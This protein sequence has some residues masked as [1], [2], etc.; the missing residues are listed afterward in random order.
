M[1]ANLGLR[2]AMHSETNCTCLIDAI[3]WFITV[4]PCKRKCWDDTSTTAS[5]STY[6]VCLVAWDPGELSHL[7][8]AVLFVIPV[9]LNLAKSRSCLVACVS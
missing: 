2:G 3:D 1:L 4:I 6:R 7:M 9:E 5:S 8:Q